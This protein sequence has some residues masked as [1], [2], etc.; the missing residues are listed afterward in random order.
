MKNSDREEW[1]K[2]QEALPANPAAL[3]QLLELAALKWFMETPQMVTATYV[4]D[5]GKEQY[6]GSAGCPDGVPSPRMRLD[7]QM[8]Q[9]AP[10]LEEPWRPP[11]PT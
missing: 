3:S 10:H 6:D 1:E 8:A 2:G 5:E 4:D 9:T 11:R 7:R